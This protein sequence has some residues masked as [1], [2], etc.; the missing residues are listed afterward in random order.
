MLRNEECKGKVTYTQARYA[1]VITSLADSVNREFFYI[2]HKHEPHQ[3][4]HI[5]ANATVATQILS[6]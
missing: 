1:E 4:R 3:F 6:G 2:S 5:P